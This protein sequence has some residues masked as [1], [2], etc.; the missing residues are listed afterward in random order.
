M[1]ISKWNLTY[2]T[3]SD[4]IRYRDFRVF[5]FQVSILFSVTSWMWW[6]ENDY[7]RDRWF[8]PNTVE[9]YW[10]R[11]LGV[12]IG[13]WVCE[14]IFTFLP[15]ICVQPTQQTFSSVTI[16]CNPPNSDLICLTEFWI[17]G[18]RLGLFLFL[19]ICV[20]E[21][22]SLCFFWPP[23]LYIRNLSLSYIR[24]AD[25]SLIIVLAF[26]IQ[27]PSTLIAQSI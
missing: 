8:L 22:L 18:Y 13:V 5:C 2:A 7:K 20:C 3:P 16:V 24:D 19:C 10:K 6:V 1:L 17:V 4:D 15:L 9:K 14:C 12:Y 27:W 25:Y 11:K 26:W 23:Y 21:V